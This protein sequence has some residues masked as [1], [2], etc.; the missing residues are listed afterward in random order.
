MQKRLCN[1]Y[2]LG[3]SEAGP[4]YLS[5]WAQEDLSAY[6]MECRD[7]EVCPLPE[8]GGGCI[9]TR[10]IGGKPLS[11]IA[12]LKPL[13]YCIFEFKSAYYLQEKWSERIPFSIPSTRKVFFLFSDITGGQR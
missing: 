8:N 6:C 4:Q 3:Y 12:K 1:D 11:S 7:S 9:W 2:Q 10:T 5:Y 13:F